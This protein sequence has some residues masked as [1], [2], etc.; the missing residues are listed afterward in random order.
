M[1]TI[2]DS[3]NEKNRRGKTVRSGG[4]QKCRTRVG[5][6]SLADL[7]ARARIPRIRELRTVRSP[8]S[9]QKQFGLIAPRKHGVRHGT[10]R[11]RKDDLL[12]ARPRILMMNTAA[13][14]QGCS[15]VFVRSR[16]DPNVT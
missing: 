1:L 7:I 5:V 15:F 9:F 14:I 6:G 16:P 2:L 4:K 12:A 8:S 13:C 3:S 11:A 10:R